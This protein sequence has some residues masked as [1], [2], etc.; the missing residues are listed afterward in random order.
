MD[1][2]EEFQIIE[3]PIYDELNWDM[4]I[5]MKALEY[6]RQV[7]PTYLTDLPKNSKY[8]LFVFRDFLGGEFPAIGV[9]CDDRKDF[10]KIPDFFILYDR[11]EE[12]IKEEITFEK[13][14]VE[15]EKI[16]TI[17]WVELKEKKYYP[18]VKN[19]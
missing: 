17:T 19:E 7:L 11:V 3:P 15:L 4:E 14:K 18:K 6:L 8:F 9:S 12:I 13:L 16:Q 5:I 2:N 1:A 10:E